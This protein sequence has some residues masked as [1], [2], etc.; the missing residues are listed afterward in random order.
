MAVAIGGRALGLKAAAGMGAVA[1]GLG[2]GMVWVGL[3]GAAL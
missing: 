1:L 3:R 2:S